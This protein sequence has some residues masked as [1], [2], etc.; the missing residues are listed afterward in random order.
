MRRLV[1][2]MTLT[3]L[4]PM[5]VAKADEIKGSEF[6]YGNW[7]GAGYTFD[8]GGTFSH[9]AI[10]AAFKSGN[11]LYFSVGIDATVSVA[12]QT[13]IATYIEGERF[14][15]AV[16]VDNRPP[17]FGE[18]RAVD[19]QFAVLT[20]QQFDRALDSFKRGRVLVVE[21]KYGSVP[22]DLSGTARALSQT[23]QCAINYR[24]YRE[25]TPEIA[26]KVDPALLMQVAVGTIT[27]LGV[28]DFN[29]LTK[30]EI[31]DIFPDMGADNQSVFWTSEA[32]NLLSG[33]SVFGRGN[34]EDLKTTDAN[35][36]SYLASLCGGDIATGARLIPAQQI[37]MREIRATCV[38]AGEITEH[39]LTKF[40][41]G[42]KVVCKR[43]G[44]RVG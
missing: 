42:D 4:L 20:I 29:F 28:N 34:N 2:Q 40:H 36:L 37:E 14:P 26:P 43:E 19:N 24:D 27:T 16:Y 33:V 31:K 17:F 5:Q 6:G 25:Q 41:F 11:N 23:L 15:V 22:F 30:S 10:S 9:C 3:A 32:L 38:E 18:A 13:P 7:T 44:D 8:Q 21:S 1:L 35:D 12:V 39:Y